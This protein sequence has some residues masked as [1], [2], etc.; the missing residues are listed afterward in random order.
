[1]EIS[2]C[3]N[4]GAKLKFRT[5]IISSSEICSCLSEFCQK[6]RVPVGKSQPPVPRTFL[7]DDAAVVDVIH[8]HLRPA[9]QAPHHWV[10]H[11]KQVSTV[12]S[13]RRQSL[14]IVGILEGR[15]GH[16]YLDISCS[17][18]DECPNPFTEN[19]IVGKNIKTK[20]S[21]SRHT[22]SFHQKRAARLI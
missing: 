14:G 12:Y 17:H 5:T 22:L 19:Q 1:M 18:H 11:G 16:P 13:Q 15:G 21:L 4:L 20:M 3:E 9:I 7:T 10:V 8:R 2:L 6:F